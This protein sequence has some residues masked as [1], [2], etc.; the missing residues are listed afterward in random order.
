MLV[1][2]P[3]YKKVQSGLDSVLRRTRENLSGVRVIRAFNKEESE[4]QAFDQENASL[5]RMQMFVGR[6]SALMNPITYIIVNV[7]ILVLIWT[8]AWQV[9]DGDV[10]TGTGRCAGQLHVSDSGRADQAGQSDHY[11]NQGAGLC[12]TRGKC[13]RSRYPAWSSPSRQRKIA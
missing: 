13:A 8:G 3:L 12:Q 6:I 2:M 5:T 7:A 4:I 11:R 9:E 1:S 10:D